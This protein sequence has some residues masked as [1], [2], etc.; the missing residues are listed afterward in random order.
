MGRRLPLASTFLLSALALVLWG[1]PEKDSIIPSQSCSGDYCDFLARGAVHAF[2]APG[3]TTTVFD[4]SGD[5]TI[6][7]PCPC[8]DCGR[9]NLTAIVPGAA[10]GS[11]VHYYTVCSD[12]ILVEMPSAWGLTSYLWGTTPAANTSLIS[13]LPAS[14]FQPTNDFGPIVAD[15]GYSVFEMDFGLLSM[16]AE[17]VFMHFQFRWNGLRSA[18]V[19]GLDVGVMTV[20]EIN[21]RY[22]F[23]T[24]GTDLDFTA[25]HSPDPRVLLLGPDTVVPTRKSTWGEVKLHYR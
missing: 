10:I 5:P 20:Q 14:F 2:S 22:V 11:T 15:P 25:L 12:P 23:P 3:L 19:K 1:C 6:S 8:T 9:P 24:G 16:P 18:Y 17:N 4:V 13:V 7:V 21:K